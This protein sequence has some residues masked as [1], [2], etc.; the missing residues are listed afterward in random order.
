MVFI[1]LLVH[2]LLLSVNLW[3]H[4]YNNVEIMLTRRDAYIYVSNNV[5]FACTYTY[6]RRDN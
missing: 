2:F 4:A 6:K 3:D 1:N 5:L